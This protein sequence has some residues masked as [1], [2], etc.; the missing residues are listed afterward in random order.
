MPSLL[1]KLFW[2]E[3]GYSPRYT[4][5]GMGRGDEVT[6]RVKVSVKARVRSRVGICLQI[7]DQDGFCSKFE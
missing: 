2:S 1:L 6:V 4:K 7:N 3:I 5:R